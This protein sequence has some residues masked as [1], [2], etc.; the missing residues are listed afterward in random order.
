MAE[1][2]SV[3]GVTGGEVQA[4]GAAARRALAAAGL[5][6]GGRRHLDALAPP[7]VRTVVIDAGV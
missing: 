5:V 7:G 4:L 2:I 1:R 6:V 3:V